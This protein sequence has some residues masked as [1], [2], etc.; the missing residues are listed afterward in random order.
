[1]N[2][3]TE[4]EY[5]SEFYEVSRDGIVKRKSDGKIFKP[6]KDKK[7]YH[8]VR[9]KCP[10][11]SKHKD[12]RKNYK[13]HRLVAMFYLDGYS[14]ELQVNHKNGVKTDNRAENLEMVTG[15]ENVLHA[16]NV[17]DSTKRKE[18]LIKRNI[19][20]KQN[21][22]KMIHASIVANSKRVI[23]KNSSGD[24]IEIY[25][26]ATKASL[27]ENVSITYICFLIKNNRQRNGY[28]FYY[29]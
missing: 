8:M 14:D 29:E 15:R 11:Y 19:T 16:W 10:A 3:K 13:I 25:D 1:M 5:I 23:K 18:M 4:K 26:S 24:I 20:N 28:Y 2:D 9:I 27:A 21:L 12:Q 6:V 17:L 7:G 22:E